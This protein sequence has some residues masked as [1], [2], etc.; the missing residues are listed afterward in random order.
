MS[1]SLSIPPESR[2]PSPGPT[3]DAS[4]AEKPGT[5]PTQSA[6]SQLGS[7]ALTSNPPSPSTGL[8][9]SSSFSARIDASGNTPG[10]AGLLTGIGNQNLRRSVSANSAAGAGLGQGIAANSPAGRKP[11]PERGSGSRADVVLVVQAQVEASQRTDN[12]FFEQLDHSRDA[13]CRDD[14]KAFDKACVS[15][16]R[17]DKLDF[18]L[19]KLKSG[20]ELSAGTMKLLAYAAFGNDSNVRAKCLEHLTSREAILHFASL[21]DDRNPN[22]LLKNPLFNFLNSFLSRQ[23]PEGEDTLQECQRTICKT[24]TTRFEELRTNSDPHPHNF[25]RYLVLDAVRASGNSGPTASPGEQNRETGAQPA[26]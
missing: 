18:S 21:D 22:A 11:S 14:L 5:P 12:T 17:A 1:G 4:A 23:W 25:A 8:S 15:V 24:L 2:P 10:P 20:K 26:R 19:D 7:M 16:V 3:E 6:K 9:P 13:R